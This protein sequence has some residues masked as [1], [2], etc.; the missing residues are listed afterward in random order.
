MHAFIIYIYSGGS[1]KPSALPGSNLIKF[2]K[3]RLPKSLKQFFVE[4]CYL[5]KAKNCFK[6]LQSNT[7]ADA[8][9]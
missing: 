5:K 6:G 7:H 1:N 8:L 3:F 4:F 2:N 9:V